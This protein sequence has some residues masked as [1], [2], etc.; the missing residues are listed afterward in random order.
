M[1]IVKIPLEHVDLS[2][3][4]SAHVIIDVDVELIRL[5]FVSTGILTE[6]LQVRI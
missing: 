2:S 5:D 3:L 6:Y 4:P 1:K